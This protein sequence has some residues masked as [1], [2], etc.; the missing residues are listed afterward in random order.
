M[1]WIVAYD[2]VADRRRDHVS[3]LLSAIG[4]RIQF[5]VFEIEL[6]DE[7]VEGLVAELTETVDLVTDRV[8]LFPACA[9]GAERVMIGQATLPSEER[10]YIV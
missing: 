3:I 9:C 1:K 6:G 5:S 7:N 2:I 10:F 8:H 4:W